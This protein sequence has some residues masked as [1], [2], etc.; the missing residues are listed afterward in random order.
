MVTA[1]TLPRDILTF[2]L[3]LHQEITCTQSRD[4]DQHSPTFLLYSEKTNQYQADQP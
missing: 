4:S 2:A 1:A 3:W